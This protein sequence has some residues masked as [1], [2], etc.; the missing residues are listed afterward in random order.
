MAADTQL[1]RAR[2]AAREPC[3]KWFQQILHMEFYMSSRQSERV[4]NK[5]CTNILQVRAYY[6]ELL[7]STA[8]EIL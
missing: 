5:V 8:H 6:R 1:T 7:T 3:A 2:C 4:D